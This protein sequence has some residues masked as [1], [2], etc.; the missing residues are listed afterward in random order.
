VQLG[1][2][3]QEASKGWLSHRRSRLPCS[4]ERSMELGT[5]KIQ[6]TGEAANTA[7]PL[8]KR[9]DTIAMHVPTH[10]HLLILTHINSFFASFQFTGTPG[11]A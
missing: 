11:F 10:P 7:L 9:L 8:C 3:F 6:H 1:N 5:P 2:W 4:S